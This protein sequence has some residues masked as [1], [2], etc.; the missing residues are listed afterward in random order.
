MTFLLFQIKRGKNY[1]PHVSPSSGH[2]VHV[3]VGSAGGVGV[4]ARVAGVDIPHHTAT[5]RDHW[6]QRLG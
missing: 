1:S 6:T 2:V 5:S 3:D 4:A